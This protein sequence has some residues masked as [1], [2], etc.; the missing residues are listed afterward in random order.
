MAGSA[1][2]IT[3]RFIFCV[4]GLISLFTAVPYAMLRG[5][6]LPVES[7]WIIFV[8]VLGLIGIFSVMAAVLPGSRT[9]KLCKTKPDDPRLF[10]LPLKL[11]GGFAAIGYLVAVFAYSAPHRWNLDPQFMLVLCP[12][13]FVKMTFDPALVAI[14]FLLAPMNAS[15]FGSFGLTLGYAWLGLRQND[16]V[17]SMTMR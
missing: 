12:M 17:H 4:C 6:D 9:A 10:I 8:I 13:Y 5:I 7:E 2:R 15:V 3:S 16:G 11:L 1:I 14:L